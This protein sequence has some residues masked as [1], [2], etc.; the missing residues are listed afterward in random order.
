M[1]RYPGFLILIAFLVLAGCSVP[2]GETP[3]VTQTTVPAVQPDYNTE[4]HPGDI[5]YY[6]GNRTWRTFTNTYDRYR[7]YHPNDWLEAPVDS[8]YV[9]PREESFCILEQMRK[10]V[11]LYPPKYEGRVVTAGNGDL[12]ISGY[13][14]PAP[15]ESYTPKEVNYLLFARFADEMKKSKRITNVRVDGNEYLINGNPARHVTFDGLDGVT[16]YDNYHIAHNYSFYTLQWS[17]NKTFAPVA[18]KIIRTF[19]PF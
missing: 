13:I 2:S 19:E 18:S 10:Q 17:G 1:I 9:D 8:P 16:T 5:T 14:C 7:I 15:D 11:R 6:E 3:V 4:L 12:V